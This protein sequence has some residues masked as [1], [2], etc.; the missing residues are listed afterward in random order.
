VPE[1]LVIAI[2]L[3]MESNPKDEEAQATNEGCGEIVKGKL[4]VNTSN[5][6]EVVW[7]PIK[8]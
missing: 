2:W 8:S 3:A 1:L 4:K 7:R 5:F 6:S